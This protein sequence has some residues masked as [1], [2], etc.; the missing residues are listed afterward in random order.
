MRISPGAM[1]AAMIVL[2]GWLLVGCASDVAGRPISLPTPTVPTPVVPAPSTRVT[3]G[4]PGG[5]TTMQPPPFIVRSGGSQLELW[6]YTFCYQRANQGV[7]AD[8]FDDDPPSV[9]SPSELYVLVQARG[10]NQLT[11][12]QTI[13]EGECSRS[14]TPLA[15]RLGGGWWVV[16]PTGPSATYRVNLFAFGDDAGDMVADVL[17]RTPGGMANNSPAP[18]CSPR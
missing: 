7:C 12:T 2:A 4:H 13:G 11:V 6:A 3:H 15:E 5:G 18:T 8:G 9:G 14:L 17:W 16:R 10:M 1:R